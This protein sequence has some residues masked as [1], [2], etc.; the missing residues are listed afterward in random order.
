MPNDNQLKPHILL[1][2]DLINIVGRTMFLI[3]VPY[4]MSIIKTYFLLHKKFNKLL[5][6]GHCSTTTHL[7]QVV[8]LIFLN[9]KQKN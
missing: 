8:Y 6:N 7:Y 4:K 5:K 3:F 9:I 2:I 1:K